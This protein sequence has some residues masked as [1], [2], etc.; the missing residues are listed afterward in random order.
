V[1][2]ASVFNRPRV[3]RARRSSRVTISTWPASSSSKHAAKLRPVGLGSARR[4]A[5][6]LARPVF[7]QRRDLSGDAPPV[8]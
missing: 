2:A 6:H 8:G 1:I 5:E 4:F 3:D 7:P